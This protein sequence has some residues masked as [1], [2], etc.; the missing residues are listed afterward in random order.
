MVAFVGFVSGLVQVVGC[1][2]LLDYVVWVDSCSAKVVRGSICCVDHTGRGEDL[3]R[4]KWGCV[5]P[6]LR[7]L[8][9]LD[10]ES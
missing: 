8:V 2:L 5:R 4:G 1:L 7:C 3:F 10:V 6:N 9:Y